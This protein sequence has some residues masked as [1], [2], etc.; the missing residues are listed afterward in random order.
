MRQ[1]KSVYVPGNHTHQV[2]VRDL[3]TCLQLCFR[4]RGH[5]HREGSPPP[6]I[7]DGLLSSLLKDPLGLH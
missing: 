2:S 4:K 7:L 1:F 5:G 3:S 6:I